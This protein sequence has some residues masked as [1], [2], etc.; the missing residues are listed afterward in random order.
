MKNSDILSLQALYTNK[1][2][3]TEQEDITTDS[4]APTIQATNPAK[5]DA[6]I[7]PPINFAQMAKTLKQELG[8]EDE[9]FAE[10][11]PEGSNIKK[12]KHETL[13]NSLETNWDLNAQKSKSKFGKYHNMFIFGDVSSG[14]TM[15]IKAF[16]NAKA[17]ELGK[18][19]AA[20]ELYALDPE[21][22]ENKTN[23]INFDV[24]QKSPI[25]LKTFLQDPSKYFLFFGPTVEA[26][27]PA[28]YC[29]RLCTAVD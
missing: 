17:E 10:G 27:N 26:R 16:C 4:K 1:I 18:S 21:F 24:I 8:E 25:L 12:F 20:Y 9:Y 7:K 23:Y 19:Q 22:V 13:F 6:I 14:K 15:S 5:L 29:I 2:F 28:A 3:I 11:G